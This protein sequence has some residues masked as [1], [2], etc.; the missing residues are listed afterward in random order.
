MERTH[1]NNQSIRMVALAAILSFTTALLFAQIPV[2]PETALKHY[3]DKPD[4]TFR[5]EVKDSVANSS[6][7]V[8]QLLLVSQTWKDTVWTHQLSVVVP[9]RVERDGA[10]LFITG[11]A[12]RE[13]LP[14]WN[15]NP[16]D[17]QLAAMRM[18][19][20]DNHAVVALLRQT[21]NQPLYGGRTE[22]ELISMTLHRYKQD[23]DYEW[24]L[25]FP[26]VKSAVRAMD[27]V[28][29]F[30]AK[31]LNEPITKFIISGA[32]KRG[33]TTWL[34]A[35]ADDRVA[36]IAPMVIDVLNMPVSLQYQIETWGDYSVQIQDYVQ[37]GIP[38]SATTPG[39]QEITTMVDPYAYRKTLTMPKLL[40]MGTNDPYWVVDNVKNY[41]DSIPGENRLHYVPNAGHDLGDGQQA[42]RALSAFVGTM[43]NNLP[44]PESDWTLKPRHRKA[45]LHVDATPGQLLDVVVWTATSTDKDFRDEQ[46]TS[47]SLGIHGKSAIKITLSA[48]S[49]GYQAYYVDLKY[50]SPVGGEYT[51][52]TRVF[53]L[54]KQGVL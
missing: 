13:G 7:T 24:P 2:T 6:E 27:A 43:L 48:P 1:H 9:S 17:K 23:K 50:K 14:R 40:F 49:E 21:P 42:M 45:K 51:Q 10:L 53:V 31:R 39:G 41:L 35:A 20:A 5:W 18:I 34:T 12:V 46:W 3:V 37:L 38:Q 4:A 8:Y 19:A 15:S 26:M 22:D 25:L 11:G 33:W 52:S 44:Y 32:S 47:S 28:Q 36:A 54:D 29:D 30:T 16:E